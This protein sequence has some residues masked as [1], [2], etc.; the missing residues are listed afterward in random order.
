MVLIEEIGNTIMSAFLL[1]AYP[2][3]AIIALIQD[4]VNMV[5]SPI[6]IIINSVINL[7]NVLIALIGSVFSNYFPA[8]WITILTLIIGVTVGFRMW[9]FISKTPILGMLFK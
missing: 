1:A 3:L 2:L 9:T 6:S 8:I 4:C 5:Y 7:G